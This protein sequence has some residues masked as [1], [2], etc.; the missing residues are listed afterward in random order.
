MRRATTLVGVAAF[1]ASQCVS[2]AAGL[3]EC[4]KKDW[5]DFDDG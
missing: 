1:A 3:C 5:D 4:T 2:P